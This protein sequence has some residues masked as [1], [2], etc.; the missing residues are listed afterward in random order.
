MRR[1]AV[2]Q[3]YTL[4]NL[5]PNFHFQVKSSASGKVQDTQSLQGQLNRWFS[6]LA[7][8]FYGIWAIELSEIIKAENFTFGFGLLQFSVTVLIQ[9][10]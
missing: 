7:Q 1:F 2:Q 4:N 5:C 6:F 10:N 9:K 3:N 8:P